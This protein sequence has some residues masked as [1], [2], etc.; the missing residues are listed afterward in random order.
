FLFVGHEDAGDN[1][2]ALYTLVA[3]CEAHG[4]NPFDYLRDVLMRVSTHPASDIDALLPHR[5][6]PAAI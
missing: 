4:V 2:A 3:T 5:W 6:A 1:I